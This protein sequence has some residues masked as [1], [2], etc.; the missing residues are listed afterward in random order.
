[1]EQKI[2]KNKV[3]LLKLAETLGSVSRACKVMG[4]SRDSFYRFRDLY[5]QGGELALREI[6]RK[7]PCI[8]N[9][10]EPY[11]EEAVVAFAFENPAY[12]QLRVSNELKKRGI[13]VSP[14]GVRSVW[15]R[16]DLETFKKRLKALEAKAAQ[17]DLILTEGQ[18]Q[19]L[20]KSKEEKEARGEIETLHPGYLGSQDTFYVGN[21]KGVGRI[22]QQTFIDTYAKVA[23][24][25]LYDRKNALVAAD[26]LNDRVV[27]WHEE[28]GVKVQRILTDRGTEYCGN[29]EHHEY[30]LYLAIEDIDHS[31][32]RAK[33]PQ[34]NGICER[35]HKTM[36]NEFYQVAFRKK[37]YRSLDEIQ[38]DADAWIQ[39]YNTDRP[40]SGKYCF[41]KTPMQTFLESKHLADE[42]DL[43]RLRPDTLVAVG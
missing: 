23:F 16:H 7:K 13:F 28:Q 22:Y 21:L 42:K 14:C 24:V 27:P 39:W 43:D 1:M 40:H 29:R 12:G 30:Q 17:E 9:R 32:T 20:E 8:K 3:G 2:I 25:K 41:G 18:L 5:E 34:T 26:L 38:E 37:L 19:A 15:Q 36:L 4:Y 33:S 35:F 11:V 6:S 31:K 10:V